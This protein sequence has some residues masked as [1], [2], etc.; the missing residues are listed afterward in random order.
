[1]QLN[2]FQHKDFYLCSFLYVN[3]CPLV[4]HERIGNLTTFTFKDSEE[5]R[6]LVKS[7][8]SNQATVNPIL[9]STAI[10]VLKSMVH[11]NRSESLLT[12]IGME[13]NNEFNNKQQGTN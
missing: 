2:Y 10:K 8:Y 13:L 3:N 5:L 9:F 7:Y 6:A 11:S 1:M 12:T 4:K